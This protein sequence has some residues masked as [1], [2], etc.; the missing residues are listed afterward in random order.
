MLFQPHQLRYLH[1]R[2]DAVAGEIQHPVAGCRQPVGLTYRPVIEP[3][4]GVEPVFTGN[5]NRNGLTPPI[6]DNERAGGVKT[7]GGDALRRNTCL[8]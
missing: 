7:D 8:G 6:T 5:G 1:F 4:D 3:D 2:R